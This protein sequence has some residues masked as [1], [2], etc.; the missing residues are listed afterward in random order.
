MTQQVL[1]PITCRPRAAEFN[2]GIEW[3]TEGFGY[4]QKDALAWIGVTILWLVILLALAFIPVLGSLAGE[5]LMPVFI[6][7]LMLGC[8]ARA[9][10]REFQVAHLFAGFS[11]HAGQLMILGLLYLGGMIVLVILMVV[12]IIFGAGDTVLLAKL[13]AGDAA[14]FTDNLKFVLL[15]CLI[16]AALYVPLLMAFWFAPALVVLR[17]VSAVDA[18]K[19]SF[20][21]CLMNIMPFILYGIV[22]LVLSII[23][24]ITM[25][26]GFLVLVPV[27]TASIYVS[28]R[29]IYPEK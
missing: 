13:A 18:V 9:Q 24:I 10:G 16:L 17:N 2:R 5:I 28:Y 20:N 6:G 27:V 26:L 3:L 12:L 14:A 4:F 8:Q 15:I 23:A 22:G 7:G 19:L 11:R 25:G 1:S 21:G 29:D